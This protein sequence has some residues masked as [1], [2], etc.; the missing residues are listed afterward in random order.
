MSMGFGNP[1]AVGRTAM[2]GLAVLLG[3]LLACRRNG[4]QPGPAGA[5]DMKGDAAGAVDA[6]D[7]AADVSD[8]QVDAQS[9][10]DAA[11]ADG[12]KT[13]SLGGPTQTPGTQAMMFREAGDFST[14]L[15]AADAGANQ[16]Q[17]TE[18]FRNAGGILVPFATKCIVLETMSAVVKVQLT[19]G[20]WV[21]TSGWVPA[22]SV[23]IP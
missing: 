12:G 14:L 2:M 17:R 18:Q 3:A 13:C 11:L 22:D 10:A 16:Q 1:S 19:D 15:A 5:S 21:G 4:P 9:S 23:S 20:S 8:A 7:A 6:G